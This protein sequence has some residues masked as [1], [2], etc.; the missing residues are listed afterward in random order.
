MDAKNLE[1]L[2]LGPEWMLTKFVNSAGGPEALDRPPDDI[3]GLGLRPPNPL[4][5]AAENFKRTYGE[6]EPR[7]EVW[8]YVHAV[9]VFREAWKARTRAEKETVS[10]HITAIFERIPDPDFPTPD[11]A[12]ISSDEPTGPTTFN[13]GSET[14]TVPDDRLKPDD[15]RV[16]PAIVA[17]FESGSTTIKPRTLLDWLAKSLLE[18]REKL[19]LCERNGC[20]HPY[21]VKSHA[22]QKFCSSECADVIR[23]TKKEAWWLANRDEYTEKWRRQ[24]SKVKKS[25]N[26]RHGKE[27]KR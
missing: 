16:R 13:F 18:C 26:H 21:F 8:R 12:A 17:D 5:V 7:C 6:L 23:R 27:P 24:R 14:I 3:Y 1:A 15:P 10:A 19:A 2:A 4:A 22:R 9:G 20:P 11:L 25:A